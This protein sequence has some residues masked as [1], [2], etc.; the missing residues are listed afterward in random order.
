MK[1][2]CPCVIKRKKHV[3][4]LKEKNFVNSMP[5]GYSFQSRIPCKYLT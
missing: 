3:D 1:W 4:S 2:P 5:N